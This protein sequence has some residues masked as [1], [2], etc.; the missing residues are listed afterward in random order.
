MEAVQI[1]LSAI[2]VA[3]MLIYLLGDVLRIFS[4]DFKAG[5]MGGM[6][7]SQVMY[8]GMA[9]L[10]TVPILMVVLTLTLP[11]ISQHD[12]CGELDLGIGVAAALIEALLCLLCRGRQFVP[13]DQQLGQVYPRQSDGGHMGVGL[14]EAPISIGGLAQS[15]T[16]GIQAG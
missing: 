5:E 7:V 6:Q 1:K 2:W 11:D 4:G 9:V 12:A 14:Y 16:R 3:V 10:F 8:L 13:L 15:A